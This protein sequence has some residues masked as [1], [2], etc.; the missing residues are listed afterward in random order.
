M[1]AF[2][3]KIRN[4]GAEPVLYMTWGRRDGDSKNKRVFPDYE[5]MQQKLS[6][7]YRNAAW[8]NKIT[9]ASVGEA[10]RVVRRENEALGND[11]YSKDGSHPS[12]KGA[13]LA[14]CVLFRTLF[15]SSL[16]S[17]Q[18]QGVL[19]QHELDLIRK[20]VSANEPTNQPIATGPD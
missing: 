13:F 17:V 20:A 12:P 10:W 4:A 14:S 11:L 3:E 6:D 2:T 5:T 15:G 18:G 7:A 16:E 19:Q 9:L 1:D 8:R